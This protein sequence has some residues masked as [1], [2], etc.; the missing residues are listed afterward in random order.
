MLQKHAWAHVG[1]LRFERQ[2]Q[3]LENEALGAKITAA[4]AEA[5]EWVAETKEGKQLVKTHRAKI[6]DRRKA[7]KAV[8]KALPTKEARKRFE[9]SVNERE[10][11]EMFDQVGDG[12]GGG[13]G[14]VLVVCCGN[15]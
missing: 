5:R 15:R 6:R 8:V 3:R 12:G 11:F 4:L 7:E 1:R 14:I 2:R 10:A 9:R 13:A